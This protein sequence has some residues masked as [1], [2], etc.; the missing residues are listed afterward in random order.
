MR[1]VIGLSLGEK[2]GTNVGTML[3]FVQIGA[4]NLNN[5]NIAKNYIKI[6]EI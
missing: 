5:V 2:N 4:T 1:N 6:L 3:N